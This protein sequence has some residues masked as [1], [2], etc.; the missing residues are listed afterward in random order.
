MD[1]GFSLRNALTNVLTS[2]NDAFAAFLPRLVTGLV[3]ILLGLLIAKIAQRVIRTGF[4]RLRID[5]LLERLGVTD[6]LSRVGLQD[7]PGQV[8]GR[9]VYYLLVLLFL[10]SGAR[11]VGLDAVSG[12]ITSFFGY[13]PNLLAAAIVLMIGML[14]G[15]FA[16]GAVTR[17][18]RDSGVEI[19]P[20]LGR[21][22]SALIIFIAGLM[23]VTQLRIDT[24]IIRAVVLVLLAGMS[25]ALALTFGLGTRDI[26]RNLVAGFYARKLFQVGETIE[27][28]GRTGT[29]AGISPLHVIIE[30]GDQMVTVPC[31]LF[32]EEA[33][34][35]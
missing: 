12:S 3:V 21:A 9:L 34:K 7:P 19:G 11:A 31:S 14:V 26:T 2:L 6:L 18:A 30:D 23:A 25:L 10:Q 35:Q 20:I 24:E 5:D 8:L 32:L 13:L 27:I 22:V 17:S 29:L 16:G 4:A 33:V 15:Q 28:S 1:N